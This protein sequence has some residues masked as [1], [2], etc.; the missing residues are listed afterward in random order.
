MKTG[1]E[2]ADNR[3]PDRVGSEN[4]ISPIGIRDWSNDGGRNSIEEV[5]NLAMTEALTKLLIAKGVITDAE[6][7]VALSIERTNYA[8]GSSSFAGRITPLQS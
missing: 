2:R 8:T 6:F 5:S 7:K 1:S 4:R 3:P